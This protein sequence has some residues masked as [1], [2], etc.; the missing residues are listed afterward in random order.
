[1]RAYEEVRAKESAL[2]AALRAY[3]GAE[4]KLKQIPELEQ[5]AERLSKAFDQELA[6]VYQ[7]PQAARQAF[8]SMA[9]KQGISVA[10]ETMK[11]RPEHFGQIIADERKKWLGLATETNRNTAY[12]AARS[13]TEVGGQYLK[14]KAQIPSKSER[15]VLQATVAQKGKEVRKLQQDLGRIGSAYAEMLA[16]KR[17]VDEISDTGIQAEVNAVRQAR[18]RTPC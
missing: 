18:A 17:P 8:E 12:Q 15:A 2:Q 5:R 4:S 6:R 3:N 7:D 9:Q 10:G 16:N 13:A 14:A 1:M 11:S